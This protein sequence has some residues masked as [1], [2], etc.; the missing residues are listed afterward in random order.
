MISPGTHRALDDTKALRELFNKM[1]HI[2]AKQDPETKKMYIEN[3]MNLW[4]IIY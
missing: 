2:L 4:N 1:V 3:P